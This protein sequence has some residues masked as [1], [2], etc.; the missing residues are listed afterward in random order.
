[1]AKDILRLAFNG[2]SNN[3]WHPKESVLKN[4]KTRIIILEKKHIDSLNTIEID[5]LKLR[6]PFELVEVLDSR[7]NDE[8]VSINCNTAEYD[9]E[10]VVRNWLVKEFRGYSTRWQIRYQNLVRGMPKKVLTILMS[11]KILEENYFE[12]LSIDNHKNVYQKLISMEVAFFEYDSFIN[13]ECTDID[14]KKDIKTTMFRDLIPMLVSSARTS[15]LSG[16]GI[17]SFQKKENMGVQWSDRKGA[18]LKNPYLKIYHKTIELKNNSVE[19]KNEYLFDFNISNIVRVEFTIKN[20]K[21]LKKY[22]IQSQKF[23]DLLKLSQ[24]KKTSILSKIVNIHL[25]PRFIKPDRPLK[26]ITPSDIMLFNSLYILSNKMYLNKYRAVDYLLTN[27]KDKTAKSRAKKKLEHIY[28]T[29]VQMQDK[30]K[31][32]EKMISLFDAI[33]WQ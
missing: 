24:E 21:H 12:G 7:I 33:C 3:L 16:T 25:M 1:M 15:H 11:S 6:I 17:R 10:P 28:D 20:N 27:I 22:G 5:S 19:F 32:K 2:V 30:S 18:T 13:A 14:F 9:G 31:K 4:S 26:Q 29:Y 23:I 8:Y